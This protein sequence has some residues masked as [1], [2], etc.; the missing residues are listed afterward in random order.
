MAPPFPTV[1]IAFATKP[2]GTPAWTDVSAFVRGIPTIKRGR[3]FELDRIEAGTCTITLDNSDR[4]FDPTYT[5]S[6]YY[7]NV[8]P[9]R[10]VRVGI[11]GGSAHLFTGFIERWPVV[12]TAGS[13]YGE[14]QITAIDALATLAQAALTGSF[15]QELSGSRISRVLTSASWPT[16]NAP[17]SWV[18]GTGALGTTTGL[19]SVSLNAVLD[20]GLTQVQAASVSTAGGTAV[21]GKTT[22]GASTTPMMGDTAFNSDPTGNNKQVSKFNLIQAATVQKVSMDILGRPGGGP[23]QVVK[24]VIYSDSG[25]APGT[26]LGTSDEVNISRNT[27]LRQFYDFPF[28]TQP[29]VPKGVV[30]IGYIGGE[31]SESNL[32]GYDTGGTR[33]FI[34]D[35]YSDGASSSFGA[36][37]SDSVTLA[38]YATYTPGTVGGLDVTSTSAKDH[39][40]DVAQTELGVF[41]IDG[42]GNAI[43]KD[44][45]RRFSATSAATFTDQPTGWTSTRVPYANLVPSFDTDHL[46]NDITVTRTGGNAQ[47]ATDQTSVDSYLRHSLELTPE[48]VTDA[49]SLREARFLL[50]QYAQPLLRFDTLEVTVNASDFTWP[51]AVSLDIG[52]RVTIE[53]TPIPVAGAT[54][55]TI[56]KDCFIEN[57]EHTLMPGG[58][59]PVWQV[60]YQ[61]SPADRWT[62]YW[63]LGTS[64]LS[65]TTKLTY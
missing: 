64:A 65:T 62:G 30:W 46:S 41:Y 58:Q 45:S 3:Q 31:T 2:S 24:A 33:Y 10:M 5:F 61:L 14:V 6:P 36:G 20:P 16:T 43:F 59:G 47:T 13:T 32:I 34:T 8:L 25:G 9:M 63:V 49:E 39:I 51:L 55:Q 11:P 56:T 52:S 57:I 48:L 19:A 12:W 21:V 35:A 1:E 15:D 18:L 60:K 44:R 29:S 27:G 50:L 23:S 42:D 38:V 28:S 7:P 26:L 40:Q 37:S 22:Q 4:R 53:R 17:N 54:S